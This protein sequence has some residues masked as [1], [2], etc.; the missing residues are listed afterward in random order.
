MTPPNAPATHPATARPP[1]G[2]P[3]AALNAAAEQLWLRLNAIL[4]AHQSGDDPAGSQRNGISIEV[5]A[6]IDSTNT[7]LMRRARAG[8]CDP[9]LLLATEQTAGRGRMGKTWLSEPGACL[10]F[11]LGLPMQ[12]AHWAGLSLAVG[13]SLADTLASTLPAAIAP[14]LQLKWPN[15]LWLCGAKLAGILVETAHV[16][17]RPYVVVGVGINITP[18]PPEALARLTAQAP[19][20]TAGSP[21]APAMAATPP[22]GLA[23]HAPELDAAQVWQQVAPALLGDLLAFEALGFS[24]FAQ[25]FARRDALHGL[26]LRLSDGTEGTG[27]GVDDDGALLLLTAQGMR[28]VHSNEVSVRPQ[29]DRSC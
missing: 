1:A 21:A 15:D 5:L 10:M 11:S 6:S 7:E 16:G 12:P 26:P 22:T 13:V 4:E 20:G 29:G 9:V 14:R 18:P 25:R 8:Q 23:A 27:C 19:S 3:L 17:T 2:Q 24:A 28:S